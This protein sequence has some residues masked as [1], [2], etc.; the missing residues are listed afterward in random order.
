MATPVGTVGPAAR[1][2]HRLLG[3]RQVEG[4]VVLVGPLRQHGVRPHPDEAHPE[5]GA[6]LGA[7]GHAPRCSPRAALRAGVGATRNAA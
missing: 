6:V 2:D 4:G 1:L 7:A 5:R 3:G